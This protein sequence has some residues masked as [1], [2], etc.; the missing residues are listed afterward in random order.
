[1]LP[2][3]GKEFLV[4]IQFFWRP[5]FQGRYLLLTNTLSGGGMLALGDLLQQSRETRREPDKVRDWT[6]TGR[7]FVAGCSMGPL[8]H[9]WYLWLDRFFVGKAMLTVGKKVLVDQL[10]ASPTIGLWY[11]VGM[12][13]MEGRTLSEGLEEFKDKFWEFY[14]ADWCVWPAAQM[15]NFYFLSPKFRVLYVNVITLGWDTYL[16]YLKHRDDRQHA[17]LVSDSS[18]VD[19]QQEMSKPLEE[20]T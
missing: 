6:R 16:S 3:A 10:I 7:M 18:A 8:L 17:D 1:M 20:K 5:L 9:Y 12:D 4:R 11:F 2:R 14:K 13:L 19:V 15:I